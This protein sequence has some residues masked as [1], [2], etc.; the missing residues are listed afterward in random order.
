MFF[1]VQSILYITGNIYIFI[2][3]WQGMSG[4]P[5][6]LKAILGF[7]YLFCFLCFFA[8]FRLKSMPI[9]PTVAHYIHT[10][11]TSWLVFTL[12]MVIALLLVEFIRLFHLY[13]PQLF[14]VAL[15]IVC[16]I[17]LYG[18]INYKNPDV[19]VIDQRIRKPL[20][21]SV[22]ELKVVAVSDIHLGFGTNKPA[23]K[24][25]VEK[26][27]A[28]QPDLILI[29][30]DLIDNNLESVYAQ[31]LGEEL[32]ELRAPL[33]VFMVPGNHEYYSGIRESEHFISSTSIQ[34]LKDS[35]VTLPNG[36][37]LIG[38]D[39]RHNRSRHPLT[40]LLGKVDTAKPIILID[41]QPFELNEVAGTGID[42]QFSGHTH[43]G[44]I[45][46]ISLWVKRLF[47][48]S[49]GY[50]QKEDTFIYVSSGL[51]LWGP[52]FRIGTDSE[53]VVFNLSFL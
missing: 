17:L 30:G 9:S 21:G 39:D 7:L 1:I 15:G 6:W 46:P 32:D 43:E 12:Y 22:R 45:W 4:W 38:R 20:D 37:Q 33:G 18:Y 27:N 48:V 16:A 29:G 31:Y 23:L 5:V 8:V 13:Q 19:V 51:S 2:R 3:A 52:P 53:L 50:I 35:V 24:K 14:F 26:I 11:G 34:L 10:I 41:H 25:Y 49:H 36:L 42:L 44:Q 40:D 28:Q 47:E